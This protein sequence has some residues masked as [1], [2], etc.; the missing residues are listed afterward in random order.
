MSARRMA[1]VAMLGFASMSMI[2]APA[3]SGDRVDIR[4]PGASID[5]L[6]GNK[7]LKAGDAQIKIKPGER[8][9]CVRLKAGSAKVSKGKI[10]DGKCKS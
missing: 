4:T 10:K 8:D 7:L 5:I 2:A 3:V 1:L 6:N 9:D